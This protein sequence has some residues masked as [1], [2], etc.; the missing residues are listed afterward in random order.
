MSGKRIEVLRRR[1]GE[2]EGR[3]GRK[4]ERRIGELEKG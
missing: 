2:D 4:K 1:G 3:T